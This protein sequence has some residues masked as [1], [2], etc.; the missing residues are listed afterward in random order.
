MLNP[1]PKLTSQSPDLQ[2]DP[3]DRYAA[4]RAR[5]EA[6]PLEAHVEAAPGKGRVDPLTILAEQEKTRLPDLIRLRYG[7]M[8]R[9]PFTFLRGAA[10]IM[11][12]DLAA[13]VR[14]D[15]QVELCGDAHLGNF[16]WYHAPTRELVFDLNDFDE[17]LPG[18]FEWDVKRLAASVMVSALASGFTSEQASRATRAAIREYRKF[19]TD[20]SERTPLDLHYYR[21]A[22]QGAL[23]H[24]GRLGKEHRKWKKAV[25]AKATRRNSLLAL[26]KLT[27]VVNGRRRIVPD[28]P[29]IVRVDDEI[30]T[31]GASA[32]TEC[33][34]NYRQSLSLEHRLLFDRFALV[35]VAR[36]VVGVGSV[37]TRCL[38]ALFEAGDGTPLFLQLK[39]AT[40]SVLEAHLGASQFK[41]AG[42]RI[43]EGQR[44]IQA[45]S[46][47]LLGW[48]RW[49]ESSR[50]KIDFYFRQLWDGKGKIDVE[51]LGPKRLA[52]YASLCGKTLAFAHARSG[53][54]MMIRGY[55]GNGKS[56]D[57]VMVAYAE[58]YAEITAQDHAQL[59][60]AINDGA[61]EAIRDI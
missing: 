27:K 16:R 22:S 9:T 45:T 6:V 48:A 32:V 49:Q 58:R 36:K 4:G 55:I 15:L 59:C 33:L 41:H 13:G 35:D 17:T 19:I 47:V 25:L 42:Q 44:L 14:T 23:D 28:P 20:T 52:A 51:A 54:A 43:V 61:I 8:S 34:N 57:N 12:S 56:F 38:I 11:A 18:P 37:G 7:R 50:R 39:Q 1:L 40:S 2:A 24:I 26:E 31:A 53:D 3:A 5:L 60:E 46:D 10:A 29:L 21:F 30:T